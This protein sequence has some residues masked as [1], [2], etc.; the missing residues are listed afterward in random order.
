MIRVRTAGRVKCQD[1]RY[2]GLTKDELNGRGVIATL[3]VKLLWGAS[4]LAAGVSIGAWLQHRRGRARLLPP[5][6][7]LGFSYLGALGAMQLLGANTALM[8]GAI[9][10][11]GIVMVAYLFTLARR[12]RSARTSTT[13]G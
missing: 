8:V 11:F 10:V 6:S 1:D 2:D 3:L 7:E 13:D 4:I 9:V 5:G 12:A